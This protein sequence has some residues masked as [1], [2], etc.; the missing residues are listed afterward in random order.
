[1]D[2][3]DLRLLERQAEICKAL[4]NPKRLQII[5]LLQHGEMAAGDLAVALNTTAANASQHLHAMK[6]AGLLDSRREGSNVIYWIT[7]PVILAACATVKAVL[8]EQIK[9]EQELYGR[10]GK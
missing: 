9:R 2:E 7:T 1:M 5:Y 8:A 6:Q 10:T 3:L 4:G